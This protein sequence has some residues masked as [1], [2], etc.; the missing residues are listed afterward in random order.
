MIS[1]NN[2]KKGNVALY[3]G[4]FSLILIISCIVVPTDGIYVSGNSAQYLKKANEFYN[5][6]SIQMTFE[7]LNT[8]RG[9]IYP[10]L[11]ASA[12]KLFD[13]NVKV[14]TYTTRTFLGLSIVLVFLLGTHLYG[15]KTGILSALLVATSK[16]IY[17][18]GSAI[19][20]D[21]ILPC[22]L[23]GILILLYQN[24]NKHNNHYLG[25]LIGILMG[26]SYMVKES[27]VF[28][29]IIP[30]LWVLINREDRKGQLYNSLVIYCFII[31]CITPWATLVY[32]KHNSI[33]PILG[34]AHPE[35]QSYTVA[36]LGYNSAYTYWLNL[37][38]IKLCSSLYSFYKSSLTKITP[39]P[40]ILVLCFAV[41]SIRLLIT[42]KAKKQ[43]LFLLSCIVCFLP[44]ILRAGDLR[45]RIGQCTI[46]YLL[47][48]TIAAQ[49]VE[50][51]SLKISSYFKKKDFHYNTMMK[52]YRIIFALFAVLLISYQLFDHNTGVM[53][54]WT[55]GRSKLLI[56]SKE[57]FDVKGRFTN[58]QHEVAKWIKYNSNK[59]NTLSADGYSQEALE[60]F[61]K[62]NRPIQEFHPNKGIPIHDVNI[63]TSPD[64]S[65]PIY[66]ITYSNFRSGSI[67]HRVLFIIYERDIINAIKEL[68]TDYLVISG[69][70]QFF[71]EYF[72]NVAWATLEFFSKDTFVYRIDKEKVK[73]SESMI[74]CTNESLKS[75]MNWLKDE[76]FIEFKK[77]KNIIK[78]I[79]LDEKD[80]SECTCLFKRGQIY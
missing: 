42:R 21:I 24:L 20:T 32:L 15:Y 39:F 46:V 2:N 60:F 35:Y 77:L 52:D 59:S 73:Y 40:F 22:F 26:F 72:N 25:A 56:F 41:M 27:T 53:E 4:T 36:K 16:G 58:Q 9:P 51:F 68:N 44:L 6:K 75:H 17:T 76:N 62:V 43:D 48:F 13:K 69:R 57:K 34:V 14:A 55:K 61:L 65:K 37:F 1:S 11:L 18:I 78:S 29:M 45:L 50:R 12:F 5:G 70:G 30:I 74:F 79:N 31:L 66:F 7:K 49:E 23:I 38:S 67:R 28:I 64:N 19:D 8:T 47:L 33:M 71:K 10:I 54:R 63:K 3:W 80:I